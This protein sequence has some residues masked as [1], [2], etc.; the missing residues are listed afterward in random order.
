MAKDSTRPRRSLLDPIDRFSEVLFGLIMALT[1]TGSLSAA[2]SGRQEVR[3]MLIGALGCNLAWGIVD[4][5]MYL[6]T[7]LT[8]RARAVRSLREI[9]AATDPA[10]AGRIISAA[11]P[12]AVASVMAPQDL[13]ALRQRLKEIPEPSGRVRLGRDDVVAALVVCLLVFLSTFPVTIPFIFMRDAVPALRVSNAVAI[14]MLFL[15]GQTVARYA[16]TN[17]WRTGLWLVLLGVV[18]VGITMALGG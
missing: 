8:E 14:V 15:I 1:F 17:P 7:T 9:Q 16:G 13:E 12:D 2:E 6:M 3:T 4:A 10:D 5:V 18:L 11:L